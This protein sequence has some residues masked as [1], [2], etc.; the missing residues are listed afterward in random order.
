M[1][2]DLMHEGNL[3]VDEIMG[4]ICSLVY[5]W[6]HIIATF[7]FLL[8][9]YLNVNALFKLLRPCR[10]LSDSWQATSCPRPWPG[11]LWFRVNHIFF[12]IVSNSC[13]SFPAFSS[14]YSF[15]FLTSYSLLMISLSLLYKKLQYII[16]S[17]LLALLMHVIWL[18]RSDLSKSINLC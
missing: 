2:I 4:N 9:I 17:S 13:A 8:F 11:N 12:I 3:N 10:P 15:L 14:T 5:C 6:L 7:V 1:K 16:S 18:V